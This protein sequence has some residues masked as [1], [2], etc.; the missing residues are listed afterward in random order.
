MC[1]VLHFMMATGI[2]FACTVNT[3]VPFAAC[4]TDTVKW[5]L[6]VGPCLYL[7]LQKTDISE[8]GTLSVVPKELTVSSTLPLYF[9][10]D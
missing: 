3:G 7:T 2:P 6:R 9:S 1:L 10:M 5:T 4:T 8:T